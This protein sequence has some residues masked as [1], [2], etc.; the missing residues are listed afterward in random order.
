M[1]G[2][3]GRTGGARPG[4][5]RPRKVKTVSQKIKNNY[6]KAARKLS[7]EFGMTFEEAMLRMAFDDKTQ[8]SV[9]AS[10]MKSYNEAMISKEVDKHITVTKDRGMA[11][12]L[13]PKQPDPA[14]EI[15]KGGK[16][17]D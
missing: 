8:D 9:R 7:K 10:I 1:A 3:K 17:A 4:A 12:R 6:L 13:P 2:I 14:F 15:L 5:G 11:V 16:N